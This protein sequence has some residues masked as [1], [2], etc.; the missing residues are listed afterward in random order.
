MEQL[1]P[2]FCQL[3][4][5]VEFVLASRGM[6]LAQVRLIFLWVVS[7]LLGG[8]FCMLLVAYMH[9]AC[10]EQLEFVHVALGLLRHANGLGCWVLWPM[11]L[12]VLLASFS[13]FLLCLLVLEG[14]HIGCLVV[15]PSGLLSESQVSI[16]VMVVS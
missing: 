10:L 7:V 12:P 9:V 8:V 16:S 13:M 4:M 1:G 2:I 6:L 14:W 11:A 15:P 5:P 3:V